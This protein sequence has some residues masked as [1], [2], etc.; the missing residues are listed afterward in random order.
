[1]YQGSKY[2]TNADLTVIERQHS[3]N[4]RWAVTHSLPVREAARAAVA[5]QTRTVLL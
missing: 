1:M 5:Q 2:R 4:G 3:T